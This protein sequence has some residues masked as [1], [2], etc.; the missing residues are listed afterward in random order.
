M[1]IPLQAS[2]Y[3]PSKTSYRI[4][5]KHTINRDQ[6]AGSQIAPYELSFRFVPANHSG[7]SKQNA[8]VQ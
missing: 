7:R 1:P 4:E 6:P 5:S 3:P 2:V 8:R